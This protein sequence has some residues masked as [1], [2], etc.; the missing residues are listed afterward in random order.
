MG[1][2]DGA[3]LIS[4]VWVRSRAWEGGDAATGMAAFLSLPIVLLVVVAGLCIWTGYPIPR[5]Y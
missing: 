3:F 4:K 1:S 2:I 5:A